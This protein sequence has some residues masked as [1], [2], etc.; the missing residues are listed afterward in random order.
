MDD[1]IIVGSLDK[2][3]LEKSI[4]D[5]VDYVGD[6]TNA[7]ASKFTEGLDK[8]KLAMKDFAI[9]Q[10][11]SV[12]L[13]KEAWRDMSKSFDAMVAAQSAG[14]HGGTSGGGASATP[15]SIKDLKEQISAAERLR[16]TFQQ[17]SP[18]VAAINKQIEDMRTHLQS[19]LAK[20]TLKESM[21]NARKEISAATSMPTK[22]LADA[23]AKLRALESIQA[24]YANTTILS[25]QQTNRLATA[26]QNCKD[27]IDKIRNARPKTIK[28]VL[29]MDESSIDAIAKKMQALKRVTIDPKNKEQIKQL[30]D[31]YQRL[32]RKQNELLGKNA[33]VTNSNNMLARSF[34]YIRN[35]IIYALTLGALTNFVKQVYEVRG[36]YELLERSLGVLVGSFERGSQIFN[37]LNQM[38]I[39]S[40]FTLMELAGA[41]KQLTAY[42]FE[43]K[44]VVDTTRRLADISAALGV[45]MER[46]TYNL[47]QIRAQTVLTARD[48]RDFANAGLPIVAELAKHYT[49]LE[50]RIVT[51]G[52]VYSRMSKKMVSYSDVMAVINKVTDEGGKFFE[53]QAKQAETLRVQMANLTL[54]WNNMLNEI[55]ASNQSLLTLPI[56]GLKAL[57]QNWSSI[58]RII[59]SLVLSFGLLKVAQM[60]AVNRFGVMATEL[61]TTAKQMGWLANAAKGLGRSLMALAANP[62]TWVFVG[63]TALVD[64]G[65]QLKRAHEEI[66]SLNNDIKKN[67]TEASESLLGFLNNKG[68]R[69]TFTLAK[70]N[71][72]TAEQGEKAWGEIQSQ[73]EQSAMSSNKLIAELL[74]IEDINERVKVGFDYVSNIQKAQAALQD[75]KDTTIKFS[76]DKGWFGLFG[77]GVVS[78]LKDYA[79]ALEHLN[80]DYSFLRSFLSND[81]PA[82][83]ERNVL[84]TS[85]EFA[86][87]LEKTAQSINN[88]IRA[89]NIT[90]PL[91]INEIYERIRAQIKAKN[92]EIKGELAQIF[93]IQLDRRMADLTNNAIDSNTS[94]WNTFMER[95]RHNSSAAFQDITD[96]WV[97]DKQKTLSKAQQEAVDKN[98]EYFKN[99]MPYAYDAVAQMVKDASQLKIHIGITFASGGLSDFQKEVQKRISQAPSMMDFGSN[100]LLPT[101]QQDLT[102]WVDA[103]RKEIKKLEADNKTYEQDNTAWA[104]ER[105]N[106]NNTQINQ[107]KNLLDL[108]HQNHKTQKEIDAENRKANAANRKANAAQKHE[109]DEVATAIKDELSIVKEIQSNYDKLRKAGVSNYDAINMASQGYETTLLRINNVLQKY[110]IDKFNASDFAGKNVKQLLDSLTRQRDSLIASGKVKTSSLKDLDVEIQKLTIDAKAYD[111]KKLTDGLNNEL[112]KLKDEYELGIELDANPEL[113]DMFADMLGIDTSALPQTFGETLERAQNIINRK[114]A[115]LNIKS[116]FDIMQSDIDTFAETSELEKESEAIKELAKWQKTFRDIFKKNIE[117]SEKML[118]DYV[119]KYGGYSDKIAE[120]EADRL[121][122]IKKL[123]EAYY[124]E[125]MRKRPEYNA[126]LNAINQGASREKSNVEFDAFKNSRYY[127]MMFENLDYIS[128]KTIRDMRDRLREL[129]DSMNDLKPEQLKTLIS[130]Y[131]KLEQKLTKRS[132]FKTLTKDLKNYIKNANNRKAANEAFRNAQKEYDAQEKNVAALKEKYEQAKANNAT[133]QNY[134]DFLKIEIDAEDRILQYLKEQLRIA[135]EKADKYNLTAKLAKSEMLQVAQ[136][137]ASNMKGLAELRDQMNELFGVDASK[138]ETLLGHQIDGLI[139]GLSKASDGISKITS[140][141][142]SGNVF[143]V[144]G[145]VVDIFTGIGDSIASIFGGGSAKTRRLNREINK[146]KEYVRQLALA[147]DGLERAANKALGTSET[148]LRRT[149]IE[150]K[151]AQ[152]AE[153][154]RQMA[155]ERS[156]RSKDRDNDAIKQYEETIYELRHEIEDLKEDVVN[157]LWGDDVKSAAEAF[158]DAWVQAWRA[159]ETTLDA[160]Q[161]KM[162]DMI[163]NLIKKA[164]TSKIVETLLKPIYK[165]LDRM[166]SSESEGGVALTTNELRQLAQQAGITAGEINTALGEF[167]GNLENLGIISP[168]KESKELSAL[169]QGLQSMSEST[170]NALEA[171]MN[172]VSQQVYLHS[173]LLTQI[174]DAVVGFDLD[175][176]TATVSQILLQLQS[177]YQVQMSIQSILNGWSNPNG[178]AVRVEMVS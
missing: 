55:G 36:Q 178:M 4:Q 103:R 158:V 78:D 88:F 140:S 33:Q 146:S 25:Q 3:E 23:Q 14:G 134:L 172:S 64:L 76:S 107:N 73:I 9:T 28:D 48:A 174:R 97:N 153:L 24:K 19:I 92:P 101:N 122:K 145:G 66:V 137:V 125:E 114:L 54:A 115:E 16:D 74:Q 15:N 135:E 106:N 171:Y 116:P 72:L 86:I 10:K 61:T 105:I 170:A 109:I 44:E 8:M 96:D 155:L 11:V 85:A 30:G 108:F 130:Q 173:D 124:T 163:Y 77:E 21:A 139:D 165:E 26:I 43:A 121:E 104:K 35:R 17:T 127:T 113:G 58:D 141:A 1:V 123:N 32:S 89:Y 94:L 157:N 5:L 100:A 126:K 62:W 132:P 177:S 102:S 149:A 151:E 131:E 2:K 39:E 46:L 84:E 176:Q 142:Q 38:A 42:N 161:E 37:E 80:D 169:Q 111:M 75:L 154:E 31:E 129:M 90:D 136:M 82:Q 110:G 69:E 12:D 112:G 49:E 168:T 152:L 59:K 87:E 91:Q 147:Y 128:T 144:V 79:E 68:N 81:T 18:Q 71:A 51:T 167:Y 57:L 143:G 166:T 150:N 22:T 41:A 133:S 175:V 60:V 27:K 65:M 160:I 53:F 98:L 40:P 20:G 52:D 70:Q 6:K 63:I 164:M 118:D 13:M 47:G 56:R 148:M 162:N 138:G 29:G 117:D 83:R 93:D 34:G 50:G 99:S 67:A 95:L 159:G 156:K 45:P 119:K 7:M 120:I